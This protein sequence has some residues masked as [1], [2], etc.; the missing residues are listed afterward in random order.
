LY[1]EILKEYLTDGRYY[2]SADRKQQYRA[3]EYY[4]VVAEAIHQGAKQLPL[5]VSGGVAWTLAQTSPTHLRL[6]LIDGGYLNPSRQQAVLTFHA[7]QPK[8]VVDLL[9]QTH[10]DLSDPAQ[11]EVDIPTGLF[12]FID[13]ELDKPFPAVSR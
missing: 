8:A 1:R 7:V 9:D 12:R 5:T 4:Q 2:Y 10:F 13:I 6:T 3:D 11:V